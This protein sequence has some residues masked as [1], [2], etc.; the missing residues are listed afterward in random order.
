ME[1]VLYY[2]KR[3]GPN[4]TNWGSQAEFAEQPLDKEFKRL[5][6]SLNYIITSNFAPASLSKE[7]QKISTPGVKYHDVYSYLVR[8]AEKSRCESGVMKKK[9]NFIKNII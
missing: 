2:N 9:S 5:Y 6:L 1:N 3:Q 8:C 7:E 4:Y